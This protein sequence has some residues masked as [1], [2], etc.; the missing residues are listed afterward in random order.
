MRI[1]LYIGIALSSPVIIWQLGSFILP[2]LKKKEQQ[3]I[4]P[5]LIGAP[6][7]FSIGSIFAYYFVVPSM[8]NF[9]FGFGKG[10][11]TTSISIEHFVS[12]ALM[13]TA[14]CGFAFL[15]PIIILV[16]GKIG[17]VNLK[18]LI[19]NW[20]YA[21]LSSVVL[22]A[23]LTPTPDPF[24]MSLVAGI[25]IVLFFISCGVLRLVGL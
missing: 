9:L 10:I 5:V 8:L 15:L 3:V 14:V 20:R 21:V 2:G 12:F 11:I 23:I 4:I 25:L 7:L 13:I 6:F 18:M 16:L 19:K 17:L 1:S 22:G 24:N